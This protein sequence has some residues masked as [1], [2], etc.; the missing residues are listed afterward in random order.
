VSYVLEDGK[1]VYSNSGTLS[2]TVSSPCVLSRSSVRGG[3]TLVVELP[4]VGI[5]G[6]NGLP[7]Y[8]PKAYLA[9]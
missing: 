3:A 1:K 4:N 7:G 8:D 9:P 5:L 6:P 2:E